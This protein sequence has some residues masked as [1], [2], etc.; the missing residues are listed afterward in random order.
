[1][2]RVSQQY[3]T[4]HLGDRRSETTAFDVFHLTPLK[5]RSQWDTVDSSSETDVGST[6]LVK[7]GNFTISTDSQEG[8]RHSIQGDKVNSGWSFFTKLSVQPIFHTLTDTAT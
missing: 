3:C 7:H 4:Y 1:M 5:S 6:S 8:S 2:L